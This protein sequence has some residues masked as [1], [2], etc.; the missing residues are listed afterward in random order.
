MTTANASP[1][2]VL[3]SGKDWDEW[4]ASVMIVA[5][6]PEIRGLIDPDKADTKTVLKKSEQ[7]RKQGNTNTGYSDRMNEYKFD[8]RLYEESVKGFATVERHIM[9]TV[10]RTLFA[11]VTDCQTVQERL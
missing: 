10:T 1:E 4:Y 9:N 7:P 2:I 8:Y 5:G 6:T 3:S 11:Q